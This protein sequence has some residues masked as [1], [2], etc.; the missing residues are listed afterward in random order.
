MALASAS[1]AR[2][3]CRP[4]IVLAFRA[5]GPMACFAAGLACRAFLDILGPGLAI[6][7]GGPPPAASLGRPGR[8]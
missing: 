5:P 8:A 7:Q 1:S 6:F 3:H 4:G 2:D